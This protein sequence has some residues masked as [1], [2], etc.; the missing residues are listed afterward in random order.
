MKKTL[1]LVMITFVA[2]IVSAAEL[3]IIVTSLPSNTP[4]DEGVFVA[5][6]FNGWNPGD[7][8][9]QLATNSNGEPQ[10]TISASGQIAFKF[11][12]GSWETVEGNENGGFLPDRTFVMGSADTLEVTILSWE[13]QGGTVHTA[14]ENVVVMDE[15]FYMPQLSRHRRIWLYLPPGYDTSAKSY[16]VLYM[17]DGQNLFDVATAFAGEWEVDEAL[18]QLATEGKQVPIVV[19]IDNGGNYR[20]GEYTPWTNPQYGGGEGDLYARFIVE[21]LKPYIDQHYR[22]LPDRDNT[23]V[24]GSSL[25]GLISHYIG[26]KYQNIFSKAGIFSPSYWFND[27][28]YDFSYLTGAQHPMRLYIM[29]GSAES[30]SLVQQMNKMKDTLVA[31]G[32][33]PD[34]LL[35]K[36]VEGGQHNEALWRSQ[37]SAA[38]Q[39][40]F[41][42]YS[43]A[44]GEGIHPNK[45]TLHIMGNSVMFTDPTGATDTFDLMVYSLSGQLL[46][47]QQVAEGK[48]FQLPQI[49]PGI[50]L[51]RAV[52]NEGI[53]IRKVFLY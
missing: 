18:N 51:V 9:Y 30:G 1:L 23:G 32:F 43:S 44:I 33:R 46:L 50:Y 37:F 21:T 41:P 16:P 34:Q 52:Y 2:A 8:N 17:H 12:R 49:T 13:D 22:T 10:I 39:W 7:A 11:T 4:P 15:E 5:G 48:T 14:A 3:T 29:G 45:P 25:G 47:T 24:M 53:I 19:G 31:A 35:L 28:V 20:I 40:L 38:Y 26:L 27:S 42:E 6:N 36:V